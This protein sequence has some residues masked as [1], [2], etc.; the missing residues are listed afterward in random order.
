MNYIYLSHDTKY[1]K[2][3]NFA[4]LEVTAIVIQI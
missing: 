3:G 2:Q 4:H 1:I